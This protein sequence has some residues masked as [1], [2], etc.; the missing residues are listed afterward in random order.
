QLKTG[1]DVVIAAMLGAEEF[2]FAT[3]PLVSLGCVMMRVCHLN[4]CPVGVATQ[5]PKLRAR[6]AGDPSHVENFMLFV[7]REVRELMAELGFRTI[8]EMVGRSDC[9]EMRTDINH[10][11]AH[12]LDLSAIL[13]QP[14]VPESVGRFCQ[15]SQ[16]H[17]LTESL[18]QTTL[19]RL[20]EPALTHQQ[21]VAASLPIRNINRA[22]GTMVG[23]EVTRRFGAEG[24]PDD[25]IR[26]TFSGSAGQSFGAFIPRGLTL[27]LAGDANDYVGKGL[28][29]GKI[30]VHPPQNATFK[31]AENVII[32]N[33]AF[34]GATSGEAY[35][36]GMAGERFG[37]RNSGV[38]AVVEGVGDH[39]CEYMTGGRVVVLGRTGRNFAAGMS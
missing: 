9:L 17:G 29:G 32:G 20:C 39:G 1:R 2:G 36:N 27:T 8:N 15:T 5:D 25:T 11:K 6:F 12:G 23:S 22:V 24:L 35:I 13:F 30:V 3:A 37:V 38:S 18:D 4:T 28:S 31:A 14:P 26:L 19:L 34:Y 33:V 16:D 10:W 7:A 21:P